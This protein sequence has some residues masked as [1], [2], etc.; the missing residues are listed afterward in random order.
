MIHSSRWSIWQNKSGQTLHV[1]RQKFCSQTKLTCCTNLIL[2]V[3]T[4]A[5][6]ASQQNCVP[7]VITFLLYKYRK[8]ESPLAWASKAYC[9]QRREFSCIRW[10]D[11]R[12]GGGKGRGNP[13]QDLE[14]PTS[15]SSPVSSV[16]RGGYP[17][18][19]PRAYIPLPVFPP[20][21]WGQYPSL[22]PSERTRD[23][24]VAS[25]PP[26]LLPLPGGES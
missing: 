17:W 14:V 6:Y 5:I 1:G 3:G 10:G 15:P 13:R 4:V 12:G 11:G 2:A 23:Q 8:Q 22:P 9:S 20:P 16:K 25:S 18:T 21:A 7:K 24:E 19:G 26:L